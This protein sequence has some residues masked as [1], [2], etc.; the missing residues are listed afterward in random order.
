ME[1]QSRKEKEWRARL[2]RMVSVGVVGELVNRL[3]DIISTGAL[4]ANLAA[5]ILYTFDTVRMS[6]GGILAGIE[7]ITVVFFAVD[8]VLRRSALTCHIWDPLQESST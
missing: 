5:G 3:Y 8:Y 2:F 4:I 7:T 1:S 6:Y